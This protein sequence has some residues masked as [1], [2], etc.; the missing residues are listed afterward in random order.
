M[1]KMDLLASN[2]VDGLAA[3]GGGGRL[4]PSPFHVH[5]TVDLL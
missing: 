3:S 5:R 1:R 2:C 4:I